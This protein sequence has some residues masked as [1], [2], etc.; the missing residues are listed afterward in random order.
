M[1]KFILKPTA[2]KNK[3][4]P[5]KTGDFTAKRG[6]AAIVFLM[7]EFLLN[8]KK[9]SMKN[10]CL[11]LTLLLSLALTARAQAPITKIF[12]VRHADR[13]GGADE[14]TAAGIARANELKRVLANSKI[15]SVYSTD[16]VRTKTTGQPLATHIGRPIRLYS[17]IPTL[18]NRITVTKGK[19]FLV[20]GHSDTVDDLIKQCGCTPPASITP[21][22]PSTQ[23]DNMFLVLVQRIPKQILPKCEVIHMKYGA[24]TN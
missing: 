15:D 2:P 4:Q 17:D 21:Q 22:M 9:F 14:L 7:L 16:F 18:I 20:V 24:V 10:V 13:N 8:S 6:S 3:L 23:F 19:R 12:I 1:L 5:R 11:L